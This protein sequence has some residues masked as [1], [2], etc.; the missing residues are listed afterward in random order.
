MSRPVR[1]GLLLG[2]LCLACSGPTGP[3]G[4]IDYARMDIHYT[5]TGGWSHTDRLDIVSTGRIHACRIAHASLDTSI[6]VSD[7]MTLSDRKRLAELF[8]GFDGYDREYGPDPWYTDGDR[9]TVVLVYG[10]KADTVAVY[11]PARARLPTRL[12]K[13][14]AEMESIW[15][16]SVFPLD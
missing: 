12:G 6:R 5:R 10:G 13:I 15:Q 11:E 4:G 2:V 9:H 7:Q 16:R 8:S 14:L 1:M 3:D